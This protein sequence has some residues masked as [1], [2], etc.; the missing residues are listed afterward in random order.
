MTEDNNNR[1]RKIIFNEISLFIGMAGVII[2]SILFIT[3]PDA[4]LRQDIELIKKDINIINTNDLVHIQ[5]TLNEI[6][7]D[8]K[9]NST[10]IN[11][12]NIKLERILTI[13][14]E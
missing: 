7:V 14:G 3:G 8:L 1:I 9:G 11:E 4:D 5:E 13:L 2:A 6:S 10:N 12:I